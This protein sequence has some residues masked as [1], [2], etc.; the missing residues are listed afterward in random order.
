[1]AEYASLFRP[2]RST[3]EVLS[4]RLRAL[5]QRNKGRDLVDLAYALNVFPELDA[6][7]TMDMF[8]AYT[9][10]K[11]IPRWEAEKRMFENSS[12]A[13]FWRVSIRS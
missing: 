12:A 9:K 5:L 6:Q 10:Q 3:E 1:M 8:G 13:G 2:T 4:T 7:R 11:P